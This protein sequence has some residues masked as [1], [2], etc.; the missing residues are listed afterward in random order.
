MRMLLLHLPDTRGGTLELGQLRLQPVPR[1]LDGLFGLQARLAQGLH[2]GLQ[3][4]DPALQ[5]VAF[6]AVALASLPGFLELTL[7][8]LQLLPS[9]RLRRLPALH[10]GLHL[11]EPGLKPFGLFPRRLECGLELPDP[12]V[13][14]G[15]EGLEFRGQ[16]LRPLLGLH[17]GQP[18]LLELL[19]GLAYPAGGV[20][21]ELAEVL[22][23]SFL[24]GRPAIHGRFPALFLGP[25]LRR[26]HQGDHFRLGGRFRNFVLHFRAGLRLGFAIRLTH[27]AHRGLAAFQILVRHGRDAALELRHLESL[28]AQQEGRAGTATPGVAVDDVETSRIE[29]LHFQPQRRERDVDGTLHMGGLELAGQTHIQPY[30]LL[31][32]GERRGEIEPLQQRF[33]E[34]LD[35][36][37]LGQP[38]EHAV[39]EHGDRGIAAGIRDERL[40]AEGIPVTELGQFDLACPGR[41]TAGDHATAGADHIEIVA[42][43]A[44]LDDDFAGL[45]GHGLHAH[46]QA[47]D[48]GGG[49]AQK[50]LRLENAGHPVVVVLLVDLGHLVTGGLVPGQEDV[51]QAAVDPGNGAAGRGPCRDLA[52]LLMRQRMTG[53]V[54]MRLDAAD[55][56]LAVEQLNLAFQ[57]IDRLAVTLA[58]HEQ[59]PARRHFFDLGLPGDLVEV[60]G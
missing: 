2:L 43:A 29:R 27:G 56:F 48:V 1:F 17:L 23:L 30:R 10:R 50:G 22:G 9:G 36:V 32:A 40:L 47:L 53:K 3:R 42:L 18:G 51:E 33:L 11:D 16:G 39:G 25:F 13:L 15:L 52:R 7:Q 21:A 28:L 5:R 8:R 24:P 31:A 19:A 45:D 12:G 58:R 37:A 54:G 60:H 20:L 4:L 14:A 34:Q 57:H 6:G 49:Q 35:E 44:L 26:R 46:E 55:H 41:R 38:H 59:I